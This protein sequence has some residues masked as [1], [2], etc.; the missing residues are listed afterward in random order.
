MTKEWFKVE[1]WI[2]CEQSDWALQN[3]GG[4][5]RFNPDYKYSRVIV[6]DMNQRVISHWNMAEGV[7]VKEETQ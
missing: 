4:P 7:A 3:G 6:K 1:H 2:E 5:L